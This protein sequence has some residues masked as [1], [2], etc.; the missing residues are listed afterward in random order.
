MNP[1]DLSAHASRI[2]LCAKSHLA[3]GVFDEALEFIRVY[4]GKN[5]SFYAHLS[6][7]NPLSASPYREEQVIETLEA[8]IR[9]VESGLLGGISVKRQAQVDV[10][11]DFLAQADTLLDTK[12][13]H[14]AA[15]TMI[16]GASL[17]EFLR[18]WVDE[19]DLTIEGKP[20]IDAYSKALRADELIDKQDYKD[21]TAW[22]G[23]RNHAAHGE[24]DKV[25]D[26][27][28][29]VIMFEGVNLFMRKY[30]GESI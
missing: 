4:A 16:I 26:R 29:I 6:K 12:D 22:A 9:Y 20:G 27:E 8:F 1:K 13:V 14:P 28:R 7:V 11:S 19:M 18:N 2:L 3:P 17:E 15:P 10:V 5:S 24:W 21:I 30:G 25:N 23:L